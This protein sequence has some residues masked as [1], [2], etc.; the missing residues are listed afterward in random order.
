MHC[1]AYAY[2][3]RLPGIKRSPGYPSS[4]CEDCRRRG[5]PRKHGWAAWKMTA[6]EGL[7][8]EANDPTV[9][10][11]PTPAYE[12]DA[13]RFELTAKGETLLGGASA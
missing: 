5:G 9:I 11:L 3:R 7:D 8:A 10:P 12:P 13:D 6:A 1:S 2:G 4:D